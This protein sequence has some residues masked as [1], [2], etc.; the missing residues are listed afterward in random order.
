MPRK[1]IFFELFTQ[2]AENAVAAARALEALLD[3]Y[4]DVE[5]KV[6]AIHD[7][8]HKG[9]TLT[10][11]IIRNLNETFVTPLDREDIVGLASKLDDVTD[12][13]YDVSETVVL[14]RVREIR[15]PAKKLAGVL[16]SAAT[17]LCEA[18]RLLDK[19]EG[20]EP[21]WIRIHTLEN[22][23]DDIFRD[24]LGELF[25]LS[26]DPVEI[27]KWK[28]IYEKLEFAIDR[29]EDVANIVEML[30]VKQK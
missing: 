7:I 16:T 18:I 2:H 28:D 15:P 14:Y 20:L 4:T 13:S 8:E 17:Q 9:D 10:H 11:D 24:A 27:I 1:S 23:G 25:D 22:E 26:Q 21:Y 30:V 3:D 19:L 29:C 12:L 6:K 5:R